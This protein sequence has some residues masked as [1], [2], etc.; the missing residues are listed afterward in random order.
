MRQVQRVRGFTLLEVLVALAILAVTLGAVGRAASASVQHADAMRERVLADWVAQNR[1]ALHAARSDWLPA[2]IQN[3]EVEQA[4]RKF[5]WR[6]EVSNTPNPTLR[7][8]VVNVYAA[9]DANYSLR[10]MTAYLV[11]YAR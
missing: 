2:G 10:Q 9:E 3:G 8:I 11:E 4:G 6:E 1:L 5:M 7:R